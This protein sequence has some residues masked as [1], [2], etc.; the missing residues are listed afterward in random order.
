MTWLLGFIKERLD[1]PLYEHWIP[2]FAGDGCGE[3][4][5]AQITGHTPQEKVS[6]ANAV[7]AL[8]VGSVWP[9]HFAKA[10]CQVHGC[11]RWDHLRLFPASGR[12]AS[13]G[14]I[15]W[16]DIVFMYR[17]LDPT[18]PVVAGSKIEEPFRRNEVREPKSEAW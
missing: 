10:S 1:N 9:G 3:K 4:K 8:L 2:G 5:L 12:A 15:D 11:V 7:H 14:T 6:V 18:F 17:Q 13:R 16:A